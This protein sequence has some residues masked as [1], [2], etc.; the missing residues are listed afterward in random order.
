MK[1]IVLNIL[2]LFAFGVTAQD[3]KRTQ[4]WYFGDSAGLSFATDPPT[5]LTDGAMNAGE[6]CAT[7]SDTNG[8]L[9]FYTNGVTVWNKNHQVMDNGAGLN[10]HISST[11]SSLIVPWPSNDS[12]F[13]IFT[14]DAVGLFNGLQYSLVNIFENNGLGKII[15]KNVLLHSPVCEKLTA[16]HHENGKDVWVL[17]H[18]W[19][20]NKFLSYLIAKEGLINCPVIDE[21]GSS[22]N[23][24][25]ANSQGEMKFTSDGKKIALALYVSQYVEVFDFD[26]ASGKVSN[27]FSL[28]N[29][30][31]PYGVSFSPNGNYLY[32]TDRG[33]NLYQYLLSLG[34]VSSIKNSRKIVFNNPTTEIFGALGVGINKKLYISI[35]DSTFLS[36]IGRSDSIADSCLFEFKALKLSKGKLQ[37]G[38][39]NFISSYF[40]RPSLEFSYTSNCHS[41]SIYF[42]A[43]GGSSHTWHI[44]KNKAVIHTVLQSATGFN[45]TD[46]GEYVVQL[47]SGTDT[48]TKTIYIEPKLELGKDTVLCNQSVFKLNVPSNHR[49]ITWQDGEDSLRYTLTQSG[50]Y[51]ASAYNI[52]GCKVSDTIQVTFTTLSPPIITKSNDTLFTD[53]GNYTYHWYYGTE[54]VQGNANKVKVSKNGT[55]R[56]EITDSNGCTSTSADFLV[57][58]LGIQLLIADK[59]FSIYPVPATDKLIIGNPK[60][61]QIQSITLKDI[62]GRTFDFASITEL[63]LTG[64]AKGLYYL[65]ITD[66]ENN[67]YA[68]KILVN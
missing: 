18:E 61:I 56:L 62:A 59:F 2:L 55:Y 20:S 4:N 41:D 12:L 40:Y 50:K 30:F 3:Y 42:E 6:G 46:T 26:K 67:Y 53:S 25:I 43:E 66:T 45:F 31:L 9:L 51:Y 49:C 17:A 38:L 22:H 47:I 28:D 68:T 13:Y 19:N 37:Y 39:P 21:V 48:V 14:T 44:F 33:K 16:T 29:I 54:T 5:V 1:H 24:P 60:N 27:P 32:I 65:E 8:N 35:F 58:G 7:I 63:P 15:L 11:Q 36:V 34:D 52:K 23:G 10:G 64:L 57:T